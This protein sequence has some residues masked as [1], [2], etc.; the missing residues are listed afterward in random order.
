MVKVSPVENV[1]R[2]DKIMLI[3]ESIQ[4]HK[5]III[6]IKTGE[7]LNKTLFGPKILNNIISIKIKDKL[8]LM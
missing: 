4:I 8:I 2:D 7:D 6:L 5:Y 1:K 3:W